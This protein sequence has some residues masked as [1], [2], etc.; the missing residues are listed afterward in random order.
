MKF[1]QHL[2]K[3]SLAETDKYNPVTKLTQTLTKL[4]ELLQRAMSQPQNA[5]NKWAYQTLINKFNIIELSCETPSRQLIFNRNSVN[6]SD[7]KG[8]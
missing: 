8:Q 7:E 4:S 5:E 2:L 6:N 1:F 3:Q